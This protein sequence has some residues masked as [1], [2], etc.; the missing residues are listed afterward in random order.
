V[1]GDLYV[2]PLATTLPE[3]AGRERATEV[4]DSFGLLNKLVG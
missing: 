2:T 1:K 4:E 3:V